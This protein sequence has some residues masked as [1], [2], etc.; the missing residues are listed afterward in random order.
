V[1]TYT[2]D[3][4][5]RLTPV[6]V[7]AL[8]LAAALATWIVTVVRMRGMDA[9][10]GTDLGTLGW[11]VGIWVTMMAAMMFPAAT[12]MVLLFNKVSSER[13]RRGQGFVPTWFFVLSYLAVW[14][15][16]GLAAYG[17]YRL[18]AHYGGD[19]FAW[20]RGGPY[21]AGAAI[22]LA[23]IYELT[24]LKS[25]CLRH[26]RSPL[27]FVLGGWRDG[28]RGALRMGVEHGGYCVGCC[29]GLMVVLFALGIMSLAWMAVV[30]VLIFAQKVLPRGEV[31]TRVFAVGFVAVGIWI[32]AA[33][34][35]VPGVT[36]PNSPAAENARMRMMHIKPAGGMEPAGGVEPAGGMKPGGGMKPADE[37]NP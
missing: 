3:R 24:P 15:V 36:Q 28:W 2:A 10:P 1:S 7:V 5:F 37:M 26:C 23:G 14:T 32:A 35:S 33:P 12:P 34:G 17:L 29:W 6:G 4:R 19:F 22:G 25:V 18:A 11:F 27:H 9:G 13:A 8:V 21:V 16:Y 20:D 30:A 31:L